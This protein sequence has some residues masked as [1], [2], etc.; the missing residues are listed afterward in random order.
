MSDSIGMMP[1]LRRELE[2]SL[3]HPPCQEIQSDR[4]SEGGKE[5]ER[6]REIFML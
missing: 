1:P 5:E 4:A 2:T 3:H 6:E